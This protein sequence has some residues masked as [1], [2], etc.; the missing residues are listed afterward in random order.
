M[1]ASFISYAGQRKE[2]SE[3]RGYFMRHK[4]GCDVGFSWNENDPRFPAEDWERIPAVAETPKHSPSGA[5]TVGFNIQVLQGFLNWNRMQSKPLVEIGKEYAVAQ[6]V[7]E[8]AD[9]AGVD[10]ARAMVARADLFN[11]AR[12]AIGSLL[13]AVEGVK[14]VEPT[15]A[16]GQQV[17][18]KLETVSG[19]SNFADATLPTNTDSSEGADARMV[20]KIAREAGTAVSVE[21]ARAIL[22]ALAS[23]TATISLEPPTSKDGQ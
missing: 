9:L 21:T 17:L 3:L 11:E 5:V 19:S 18:A 2:P 10:E 12:Q 4:T 20:C 16:F 14:Y 13:G 22:A 15:R 23:P 1:A 8:V 7:L 6:R